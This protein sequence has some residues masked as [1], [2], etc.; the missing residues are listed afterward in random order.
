[1]TEEMTLDD[2]L[3]FD[4]KP[5]ED[6]GQRAAKVA[7]R[8]VC[9]TSSDGQTTIHRFGSAGLVLTAEETRQ[10]YEFMAQTARIWGLYCD[11]HRP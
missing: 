10:V 2:V 1:M 8:I 5:L 7:D 3:E 6:D 4:L 9:S 11:H